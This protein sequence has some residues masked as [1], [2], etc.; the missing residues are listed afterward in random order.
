M[1]HYGLPMY[2]PNNDDCAYWWGIYCTGRPQKG[3]LCKE[4]YKI[5]GVDYTN[6][7]SDDELQNEFW[8]QDHVDQLGD[9]GC[10]YS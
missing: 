1:T 8:Q 2:C 5:G 7:H 3:M 6:D 10:G 9:L 4:R